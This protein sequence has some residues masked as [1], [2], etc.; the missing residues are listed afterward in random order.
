MVKVAAVSSPAVSSSKTPPPARTARKRVAAELAS[1]LNEALDGSAAATAPAPAPA[2]TPVMRTSTRSMSSSLK[3]WRMPKEMVARVVPAAMTAVPTM[4]PVVA[5]APLKS[6][7]VSV[8]AARSPEAAVLVCVRTAARHDT[9][10]APALAGDS[11]NSNAARWP[12]RN[13]SADVRAMET[14]AASLS[15]IRTVAVRD[16]SRTSR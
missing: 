5:P 16:A 11:V 9:L 10:I 15:V 6:E 14:P 12:S 4:V 13:S 3:S 7:F 2:S 8:L 1:I